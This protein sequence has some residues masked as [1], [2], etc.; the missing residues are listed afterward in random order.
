MAG[1]GGVE[2]VD[3]G[4]VVLIVMQGHYLVGDVGFERLLA[5]EPTLASA[6]DRSSK[7]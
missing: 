5:E 3:V 4:L 7:A 2:I 1:G 6:L